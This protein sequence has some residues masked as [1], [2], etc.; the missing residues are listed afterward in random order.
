MGIQAREW[1]LLQHRDSGRR[2]RHWPPMA[3]SLVFESQA[4]DLVNAVNDTNHA[5]DVFVRNL[6][7]HTTT[8]VS[9]TPDGTAT[10]NAA[11]SAPVISPD[12][13]YVAFLS[14][15]NNLTAVTRRMRAAAT[16]RGRAASST[17][18]TFRPGRRPSSTP[19]P[20]ARR[21]TGRAAGP[22]FSAPTASSL[23]LV[24]SSDNLTGRARRR[25]Q[26]RARERV[27]MD[28]AHR[29]TSTSAT[30]RAS[31]PRSA[32]LPTG[33]RRAS[34]GYSGAMGGPSASSSARTAVPWLSTAA[35]RP[36]TNTLDNSPANGGFGGGPPSDQ[37]LPARPAHR[38]TTLISATRTAISG[39][40]HSNPVFS[41][42]GRLPAF[43]SNATNLTA[44][45]RPL[46]SPESVPR[47]ID[48][49]PLRARPR[50]APTTLVSVT[51]G[52]ALSSGFVSNFAFSPDSQALPS[53]SSA[54]RPD[55]QPHRSQHADD[56]TSPAFPIGINRHRTSS[57]QSLGVT[58][59]VSAHPG[60]DALER[61][62]DRSPLQPRRPRAGLHLDR[63][64]PD[65]ESPGPG[66]CHAR[67]RYR[68]WWCRPRQ[69]GSDR[70]SL[71]LFQ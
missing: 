30:W 8:A 36:T 4:T 34:P 62:R 55:E 42:D 5:G 49:G 46:P 41:P 27:I 57:C 17:S 12:G 67:L 70:H 40:T 14:Q 10:G 31:P 63:D 7:T 65:A 51:P 16:A 38:T 32:S 43:E 15:A 1:S 6:V 50:S 39:R 29:N 56:P 69:R 18:A 66:R 35:D 59:L 68:W 22:S 61:E 54:E 64:R 71:P 19:P 21:P 11:S 37:P 24:D 58:A 47:R 33:R 28:P 9:I 48:A 52:G 53:S 2:P 26:Q 13:R 25:R 60:R 23:A 20:T 3:R 45:P 44:N